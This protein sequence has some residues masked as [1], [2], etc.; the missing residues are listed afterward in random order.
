MSHRIW[1]CFKIYYICIVVVHLLSP[2]RFF[3]TPWTA[4]HQASLSTPTPGAC[5][6]S[7]WLSW[8]CHPAISSSVTPFSSCPQFFPAS[9]S[10]PISQLFTLDGQSTGVSAS[11]LPVNIQGWFP[12]RLTCLISFL[13]KGTLKSLLQYHNLKASIS[14]NFSKKIVSL[15]IKAYVVFVENLENKVYK[16]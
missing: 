1:S 9:G 6:N 16:D 14:F 11:V 13:S 10:F 5:S 8:W 12:L 3:V 7:C 15:V 2:I 4:A